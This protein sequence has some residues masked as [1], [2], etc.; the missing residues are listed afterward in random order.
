MFETCLLISPAG[1]D[2]AGGNTKEATLTALATDIESK[3]PQ[4]FDMVEAVKNF[5]VKYEE[6]MNT[7][8]VQELLRYNALLSVIKQT[9][10]NVKAAIRGD[11]VMSSDL[12]IVSDSLYDG[13][14]PTGWK[15]YRTMKPLASWVV[16]LLR[17]IAFLAKWLKEG[18]PPIYWMPG[19]FFTQSFLTGTLQ[20]F[21]RSYQIAINELMFDCEVMGQVP[22]DSKETP[23]D[24]CYVTGLYMSGARWDKQQLKIVDSYKRVLYDKMPVLWL[25]PIEIKNLPVGRAEYLCPVFNTSE[26]RGTLTT[27]GVSDNYV[28]AVRLPSDLPESHWIRRAVALLC[29]LPY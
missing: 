19:F 10:A 6:S 12:E 11:I 16:D 14:V 29:Q 5:P 20:N 22:E 13:K 7:V 9:L 3:L 4:Q 2:G 15:K 25:K 21:A 27:T 8:L 17:R 18:K 26:R 23:Q 24:G 1:G 28:I